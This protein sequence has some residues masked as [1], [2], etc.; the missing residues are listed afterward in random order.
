MIEFLL[1]HQFWAA[2]ALY[3]IFSAAVS[4]MP[5]PAPM[6]SWSPPSDFGGGG[7]SGA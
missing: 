1:E 2:V 3:W 7:D 5:E 4:S 6:P